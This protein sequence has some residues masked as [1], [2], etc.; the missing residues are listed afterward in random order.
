MQCA[1]AQY[2]V[3]SGLSCSTTFFSALSQ[4]QRDFQ[5]EKKSYWTQK[6]VICFYLQLLSETFLILSRI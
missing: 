5:A 3:I 6:G 1:C 4:E 2:T